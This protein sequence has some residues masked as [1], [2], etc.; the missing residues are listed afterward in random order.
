MMERPS[1]SISLARA[2]TA[3]APSPLITD[4]RDAIDRICSPQIYNPLYMPPS[5]SIVWPVI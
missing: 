2:N 3:N 4:I 5:T 1:F